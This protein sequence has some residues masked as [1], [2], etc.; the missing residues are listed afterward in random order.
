MSNDTEFM[1]EV[2]E[3]TAILPHPNADRLELAHFR[4]KDGPTGYTCV[5]QKDSFRVGHLAVYC[6][7]DCIVPTNRPEFE[8]LTQRLD[9]KGKTEFRLRA[10]RIRGVYSEGLLV[11]MWDMAKSGPIHDASPGDYWNVGDDFS[12]VLGVRYHNPG[13]ERPSQGPTPKTR[14]ESWL[15]QLVPQYGVISLRK[16]PWL[17]QAGEPVII[18]EKIHGTNFRFG[19]VKGKWVVGSHRTFKTDT[20]PWY[21]RII[22][23]IL[24]RKRS[25]SW[26]GEDIWLKVASD[27]NLKS[28][29]R[30]AAGV[31]F[32][33]EIFGLTHGG[34]PIQDLTYGYHGPNVRVFDAY[35]V[36]DGVWLNHDQLKWITA[37]L[38]L[39]HQP[40]VL[41]FGPY[42]EKVVKELAEGDTTVRVDGMAA[43]IR[44]GVVVE[45]MVPFKGRKPRKGKYVGEGYRLRS[46][47]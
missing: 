6:S 17:F 19:W 9:G 18:T 43:N 16:E 4:T 7:V 20:R 23:R 26:Y 38:D 12:N 1:C 45:G 47:G 25:G 32:Y 3:I 2:V 41:Y 21:R 10:A 13:P 5:V 24:G 27:H 46:N 28:K 22:D 33:G 8:F 35:N 39:P 11:P 36:A 31:V 29:C 40:P 44:E 15:D 42:D 34:K 30:D 37:D 14:T